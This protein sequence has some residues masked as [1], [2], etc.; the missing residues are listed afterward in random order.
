LHKLIL[1]YDDNETTIDGKTNLSFS[2]DVGGVFAARGW[3]VLRIPD[4]N[5]YDAAVYE[6]ANQH[7]LGE[8]QRSI[9]L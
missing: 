1:F 9:V 2:E 3:N 6:K 4:G 7:L 5:L 8:T